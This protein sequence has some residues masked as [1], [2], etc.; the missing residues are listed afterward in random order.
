MRRWSDP[1]ACGRFVLEQV[2]RARAHYRRSAALEGLITP[3]CRPTLWAM[4]AI[5]RGILE[6]AAGDPHC[7]VSDRRLRLSS[8]QKGAIAL[9]AKWG[10][11]PQL[12]AD[13]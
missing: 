11:A 6:K 8:W 3:S 2:E 7:I 10:S 4:T 1:A 13:G 5:Y 9:R 12:V